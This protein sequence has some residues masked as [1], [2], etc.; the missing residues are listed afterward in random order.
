MPWIGTAFLLLGRYYMGKKDKVRVGLGL[1]FIGDTLW[2]VVGFQTQGTTGLA[3]A[4]T[5]GL[6]AILDLIGFCKQKSGNK[7]WGS[8]ITPKHTRSSYKSYKMK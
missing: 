1:S 8:M 4:F 3:M 6:M 7:Y 2:M 5:G